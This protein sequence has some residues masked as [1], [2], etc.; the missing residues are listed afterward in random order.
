MSGHVGESRNPRG[1]VHAVVG[2]ARGDQRGAKFAQGGLASRSAD[3]LFGYQNA[4][5]SFVLIDNLAITDL[6]FQ[7][8]ERVDPKRGVMGAHRR[9]FGHFDLR[10]KA[11][12]RRF[13]SREF[14]PYF[15]PNRAATAI[16]PD[17]IFG[18]K[19]LTVGQLHVYADVVLFKVRYRTS[20]IY[21]DVQPVGPAG[22]YALDVVLP[23]P[24]PIGVPRREVADVELGRGE[25]RDLGHLSFGEEPV[26]NAPLV[27]NLNS[28]GMET[29]RTRSHNGRADALF[30][31]GNIDSGQCQLASE[32]KPCRTSSRNDYRVLS[33]RQIPRGSVT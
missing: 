19:R 1:A 27:E 28:A 4:Y 21:R 2:S 26:S 23:Q 12:C 30:H 6:I 7:S 10:D 20:A 5:R 32:H 8:A 9:L 25:T 3:M 13:P 15:L 11:A 17:E 24:Q 22:K 29:A 31:D 18:P 16:A 14:N 33:H